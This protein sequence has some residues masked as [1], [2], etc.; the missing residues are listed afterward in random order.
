MVL[1]LNYMIQPLLSR[2]Q[3]DAHQ[4]HETDVS[5]LFDVCIW[6]CMSVVST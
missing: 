6:C 4:K 2:P 5:L 1:V 3:V